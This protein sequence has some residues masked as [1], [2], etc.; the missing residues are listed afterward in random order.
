[1]Y[2]A[3]TYKLTEPQRL[4]LALVEAC[5]CI[6]SP[7]ITIGVLTSLIKTTQVKNVPDPII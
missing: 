4:C 6:N 3:I 5:C 2:M 1:M 7:K